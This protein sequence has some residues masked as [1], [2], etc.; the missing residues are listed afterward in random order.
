[1][2]LKNYKIVLIQNFNSL[3]LAYFSVSLMFVIIHLDT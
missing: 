3:M 2:N 1:M